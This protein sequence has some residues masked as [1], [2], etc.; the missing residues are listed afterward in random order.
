MSAE[1]ENAGQGGA[2]FGILDGDQL[3]STGGP[4]G[5]LE[6]T[7]GKAR[8]PAEAD[9]R[10]TTVEIF[11]M[12]LGEESIYL[13][14]LKTWSQ[15]DVYKWRVQGKLPATPAG[16][17][18]AVDHVKVAGET[19]FTYEPDACVRLARAFNDWLSLERKAVETA[20]QQK[21]QTPVAQ[22]V[23]PSSEEEFFRFQVEL[24]KTGQ[25]HIRCFEGK[26]EAANVAVTVPGLNSLF[27]QGLMRKPAAWKVGALRDWLE[28]DAK[29]FKFKNGNNELAELERTLNEQYS[30]NT[31]AG[32]AGDVKVFLNPAAASGFD[33]QF[34]ATANGLAENKRRHLDV[35]AMELLSDP[36]RCRVLRKGIIVKLV[37]PN[38]L[39]LQKTS[40]GGERHLDTCP[41]NTLCV[42]GEDGQVKRLDLSQPVSHLGFGVTELAALFNH[43]AI[44]RRASKQKSPGG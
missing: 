18:V 13:V 8:V 43:P 39:F 21:S 37:P 11:T 16:L 6:I 28:L 12:T 3:L 4:K 25:P 19:V 17:E 1:H 38:F 9:G 20:T 27:T 29:V 5:P 34:P 24:D 10:P 32:G 33:I 22:P 7:I 2:P 15:M 42:A 40:D 44:N 41:E 30:P 14:P 31:E 26:D 35:E 36:Q 23:T